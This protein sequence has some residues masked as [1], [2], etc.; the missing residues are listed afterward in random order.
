[1]LRLEVLLTSIRIS[2]VVF[3]FGKTQCRQLSSHYS[4]IIFQGVV[5]QTI[6]VDIPLFVAGRFFAG[7]GVGMISAAIPLYQSETGKTV[8]S[9]EVFKSC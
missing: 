8:T 1:M 5:L 6:A 2:V 4:L 9:S 3:C 7:Y